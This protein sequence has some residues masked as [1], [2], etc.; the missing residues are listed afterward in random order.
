MNRGVIKQ[1]NICHKS[2]KIIN[3][4]SFYDTKNIKKLRKKSIKLVFMTLKI[5]KIEKKKSKKVVFM[6]LKISKIKK[7]KWNSLIP[8]VKLIS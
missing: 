4:I 3:K 7:K 1:Q 8:S 5:S 2:E 6:T